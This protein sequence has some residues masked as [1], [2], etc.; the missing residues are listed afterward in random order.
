MPRSAL[1]I[2]LVVAVLGPVLGGL[3]ATLPRLRSGRVAVV[4]STVAVAAATIVAAT[5]GVGTPASWSV[6]SRL[7]V[8]VDRLGGLLMVFVVAVTLLVQAFARRSLGG[9]TSRHRFFAASGGAAAATVLVVVAADLWTLVVAWVLVS[10]A[11]VVLLRHDGR[12]A[13]RAAA[14]R[15]AAAFA[16]GDLALLAAALVSSATVGP[17]TLRPGALGDVITADETLAGPV[18]V[19]TVLAVA[20][21]LAALARSAQPPAQSWL[22]MSVAAPTPSSA[23][24]HAGVVNGSGLLL[25][26]F[27]PLLAV[28][29]VATATAVV[30]GCAGVLVGSAVMRTRADVKGALAWST[31]AQ[32]GFM[33]I[34]CV[35]G[36]LGPAVAHLMAHGMYKANLFLGSGST[37]PHT[38]P[39]HR[40]AGTP[41]PGRV[42]LT[43]AVTASTVGLAWLV[44]RPA[45]LS[46]AVGIVFLGFIAAT[47]AQAAAAWLRRRQDRSLL[48][49]AALVALGAVA[50][51]A[52]ALAEGLEVWLEPSLP[53]VQPALAVVGAV[54]LALTALTGWIVAVLSRRAG[55]PHPFVERAYL[56]ALH[57]GD[58]ARVAPVLA[59]Q[60]VR[61]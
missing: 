45:A 41:G 48:D 9:D 23:V 8:E 3:A 7:L 5:S 19:V 35:T 20:G 34:Q 46:G 59:R 10:V 13:A 55:P 27:A 61:P 40:P 4:G 12:P 56:W 52:L 49:L 42:A 53:V 51:A 22:P 6:G 14:R 47:V 2:L 1:N 26:R 29:P 21:V 18:G 24:L 37:V 44:V 16:V 54:A 15:A 32:M 57:L 36:L 28:S 43:I 38:H 39:Q 60:E 33:A 11:T 17:V 31:V 25:I 30:G 50:T 58:P